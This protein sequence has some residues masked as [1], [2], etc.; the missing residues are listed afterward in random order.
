MKPL[1]I[2]IEEI[3]RARRVANTRAWRERNANHIREQRTT[4][5]YRIANAEHARTWRASG[6]EDERAERR[7]RVQA[8]RHGITLEQLDAMIARGCALSH[9][10]PCSGVLCVDHDHSCCDG[11]RGGSCGECVRGVLCN[12]HN[13]DLGTF[14]RMVADGSAAA[15]GSYAVRP[16]GVEI[17]GGGDFA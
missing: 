6:D 13:R 15:Y 4:P 9:V 17:P 10:S 12:K 1:D 2:T 3:R 16:P 5:A 11:P 8:Q 7:R 14:E